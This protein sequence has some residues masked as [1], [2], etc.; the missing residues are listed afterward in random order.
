[1]VRFYGDL[2]EKLL[3]GLT[4]GVLSYCHFSFLH[5]S[6]KQQLLTK[7]FLWSYSIRGVRHRL[8]IWMFCYHQDYIVLCI[9]KGRKQPRYIIR[10]NRCYELNT[11]QSKDTDSHG[12]EQQ[13]L[14]LQSHEGERKFH[15]VRWVV[16]T[17]MGRLST[18]VSSLQRWFVQ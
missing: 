5:S 8:K 14:H 7:T 13:W 15:T 18:L 10:G 3:R 2:E 9:H 11:G 1:M 12:A 6:F 4:V 16:E 17:A